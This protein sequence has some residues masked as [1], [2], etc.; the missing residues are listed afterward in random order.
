MMIEF[1]AEV[2]GYCFLFGFRINVPIFFFLKLSS[3]PSISAECARIQGK[4][5]KEQP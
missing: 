4:E 3:S 5:G 1:P 2:V